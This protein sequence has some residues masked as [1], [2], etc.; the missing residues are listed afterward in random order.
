M[1]CE[2]VYLRAP[3]TDSRTAVSTHFSARCVAELLQSIPQSTLAAGWRALSA[4]PPSGAATYS[5]AYM[6]TATYTI[7]G[8][9]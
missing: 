9:Y 3:V 5:N 6:Y 8:A 2:R 4:R 7:R 1:M